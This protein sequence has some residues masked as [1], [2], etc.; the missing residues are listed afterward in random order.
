MKH[1][2]L[3]LF[4]LISPV[5][6]SASE[7]SKKEDVEKLLGLMKADSMIE[8]MHSQMD[9]LIQG[10]NHQFQ[11]KPSEQAI[12]D[13]HA[14]KILIA[15]KQQV[16]W[17][18]IKT[19]ITDIY[20]KHYTEQEI[21]DLLA[22]YKTDTGQS[23]IKKMPGIMNESIQVSQQMMSSFIPTMKSI[24]QELQ[25]ELASVRGK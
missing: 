23:M 10:M 11:I 6:S 18:K 5:I 9:Q 7:Q 1:L 12:Y 20:V 2:I 21:Q 19:P 25:K 17:E 16:N 4:L 8:S 22:F 14:S 15:M 3:S 13:K 24:S